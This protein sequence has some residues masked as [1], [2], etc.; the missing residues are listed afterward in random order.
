M[1]ALLGQSEVTPK[2]GIMTS[3]SESLPLSFFLH[4]KSNPR[5]APTEMDLSYPHLPQLGEVGQLTVQ[6]SARPLGNFYMIS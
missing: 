5:R 1:Y 2:A 3:H 6:K 4:Q